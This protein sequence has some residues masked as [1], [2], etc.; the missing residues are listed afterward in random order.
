MESQSKPQALG[1]REVQYERL[2]AGTGGSKL[3]TMTY[4]TQHNRYHPYRVTVRHFSDAIV[5]VIVEET[6]KEFKWSNCCARAFRVE[7]DDDAPTRHFTLRFCGCIH[8]VFVGRDPDPK[9]NSDDCVVLLLQLK[10]GS[11]VS[12][13]GYNLFSFETEEPVE[14]LLMRIGPNWVPY[15]IALTNSWCYYTTPHVRGSRKALAGTSGNVQISLD[16]DSDFDEEPECAIDKMYR[17]LIPTEDYESDEVRPFLLRVHLEE[18]SGTDGLL[19]FSQAI[20]G[21]PCG[22]KIRVVWNRTPVAEVLLALT[23]TLPRGRLCQFLTGAEPWRPTMQDV[24]TVDFAKTCS[25]G[26][27]M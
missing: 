22:S 2:S 11:Y 25:K 17:R 23:E 12:L 24:I 14:E 9:Y 26:E 10:E 20:A 18:V 27:V 6:P 15:S 8:A 7:E 19:C 5:G 21:G 13:C 1:R 4:L 3:A 16:Y